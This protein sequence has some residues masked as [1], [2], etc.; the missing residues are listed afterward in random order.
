MA[1]WNYPQLEIDNSKLGKAVVREAPVSIKDLYNVCKAIRG[2]KV[3]DAKAFL[4]RV[5]NKEEA[6]PFWRYSHGSSHRDNISKKWKIKNGRYPVK[7][8]KYVLKA[9][10]NAES[11]AIA[12]GLDADS[13]K[14]LH[15]AAH[16]GITLKRYMPRAF[17]R[18]TAKN[19]R[20]SNIEV[21]VGEK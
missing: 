15:I 10:N 11:N 21:I 13:I 2:M 20:T 4:E 14:I 3:K 6:L 18:A 12:K 19:R 9:L 1:S 8:I 16:K 17:G 7:A 5:Q